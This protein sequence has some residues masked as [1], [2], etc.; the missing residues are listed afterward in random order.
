MPIITLN[1]NILKILSNYVGK[2]WNILSVFLLVPLYI[3][4]LGIESYGIIGF[5][6]VILGIIGF[7]DAGMSSA[8]TRE[9]A[10]NI[11]TA[12]KRHLLNKV[13]I[14]Y[15]GVIAFL[16]I[17]IG[18]FSTKIA[19]SWLTAEHI[20][21]ADLRLYVVLIG[22]G[23]SLQLIS[24]LYFGA[25]FG[26]DRQ[27]L[28]NNYQI[29]WTTFKSLFVIVLFELISA[30]LYVFLV[31]QVICNLIYIILMR[32]K[33]LKIINANLKSQ[34]VI[35]LSHP[36]PKRVLTYIGGMTF[37]TIISA[38]NSQSDKLVISYFFSLKIFSYYSIASILSQIPVM[39]CAPLTSFV[40][41][42]LSRYSEQPNK[43]QDI[44]KTFTTLAYTFIF[45]LSFLIFFYPLEVFSLWSHQNVSNQLA[46][47]LQLL[48]KTLTLGSMLL[49]MQFPFYYALLAHSKTKYTVYQ[50]IFQVAV[51]VPLLV[52]CAKFFGIKYIGIPWLLI[53]L[54]AF[55]YLFIICL[56][57][58]IAINFIEFLTKYVIF[59]G[60]I[61]FLVV[62]L[63]H[64]I[65]QHYHLPFLLVFLL[66][67]IMS[68]SML[69]LTDN[70]I[71][72]RNLLSYRHLYNF[73]RA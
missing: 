46:D 53:N 37:V 23:A 18:L 30:D 47:E 42:L 54:F 65:Y 17:L 7:A 45:A 72:R 13:E 22:V 43:F 48:I 41:P 73:P 70:I 6:S 51:G 28:A 62:W 24:S 2:L 34:D 26:L 57:S 4:Y 64:L 1:T 68:L 69:L 40:F 38:I 63:G 27:V 29:V 10:L 3:H 50:G 59:Q 33:A 66:S 19:T 71:H 49:A 31:W 20:S 67:A 60:I 12:E 52:I 39:V 61:G 16:C 14:I 25:L 9:F 8:I 56:R 11:P 58:Y 5:Y 44:F 32:Q 15:W 55:I 35:P 21:L 36:I